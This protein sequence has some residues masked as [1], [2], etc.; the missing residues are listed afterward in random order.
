M[1]LTI[2]D[3]KSKIQSFLPLQNAPGDHSPSPNSITA[4]GNRELHKQLWHI[5][6]I[7]CLCWPS[8]ALGAHRKVLPP[9]ASTGNVEIFAGKQK[10]WRHEHMSVERSIASEGGKVFDSILGRTTSITTTRTTSFRKQR[11]TLNPSLPFTTLQ[12]SYISTQRAHS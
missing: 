5:G 4:E 1:K 12:P 8:N 6:E 10:P 11:V 7:F 9:T 2:R 3:W